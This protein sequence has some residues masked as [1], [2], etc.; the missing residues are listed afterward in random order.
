[1][2]NQHLRS[3]C[4]VSNIFGKPTLLGGYPTLI[5]EFFPLVPV[6][7]EMR[8]PSPMHSPYTYRSKG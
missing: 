2:N 7:V 4:L 8:T 6:H 1:M 3:K 5:E